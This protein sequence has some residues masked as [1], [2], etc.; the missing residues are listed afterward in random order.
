MPEPTPIE[1]SVQRRI[2]AGFTFAFAVLLIIA[3]LS[4]FTIQKLVETNGLVK[5]TYV[6]LNELEATFSMLKSAEVGQRGYL[7]TANIEYLKPYDVAVEG[8]PQQ[9]RRIR[10]LME[11]N[12]RQLDRIPVLEKHLADKLDEFKETIR[13]RK[14]QGLA[15]GKE[16]VV[17]GKG[18]VSLDAIRDVISVMQS[19]ERDLLNH[20]ESEARLFLS[21]TILLVS[22]GTLL[23]LA[24]FVGIYYLIKRDMAARQHAKQ[25]LEEALSY[26]QTIFETVREPLL[27]LDRDLRVRTAN[28]SFFQ[29]FLASKAETEQALF[30]E[31][32][33]GQ[34]NISTLRRLLEDIIPTHTEVRDFEVDAEFPHI[35]RRTMLLNAR[36]LY[37]PG[38]TTEMILLAIEDITERKQAQEELLARS[39]EL[40]AM[41]K[42]L[43]AFS[44]SV[45]HDL[46]APIR[47]IDGFVDLLQRHA[48]PTLDE[49]GLRYLKTIGQAAQKMGCLIDDLLVF[50]RMGRSEL[51]KTS[52]N[53]D[54]VVK[55]VLEDLAPEIEGRRIAWTIGAL[56]EVWGDQSMLRQ[57]VLNLIAN[58][59][60]YTRTRAEAAIDIGCTSGEQNEVVVFVRDNGVGF[61]MQYAHKLF[62]VFQRLHSVSEFE[63]TGIG[64]ANVRR[65]IHRHGGRTWA[66]G[67]VNHGASFYVA[68]PRG[69]ETL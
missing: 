34:W 60:K 46:R 59:V 27:V 69:E 53:L 58:A 64:L 31:L 23:Q 42:E 32:G 57:V 67:A 10:E 56:P 3:T 14:D 17:S 39:F 66:E 21:G 20:R 50:S 52:V 44:Y 54:Q 41:N 68:L 28:L 38:S 63:G 45:S 48:A 11:D 49:K 37:R 18:K 51:Y 40:E 36:I 55:E 33:T 1:S 4:Y 22:L 8:I 5:H 16:I 2:F 26:T 47:H 29:T 43:E 25:V 61:D 9:I 7:L 62:G 19:D 12:P 24:L 15:A 65:I 30:Y 35:G 13:V 6:V